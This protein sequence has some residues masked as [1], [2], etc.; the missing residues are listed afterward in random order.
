MSWTATSATRMLRHDVEM[1]GPYVL[2]ACRAPSQPTRQLFGSANSHLKTST[3]H[4]SDTTV[5]EACQ[6]CVLEQHTSLLH[7]SVCWA[8]EN[9][10]TAVCSHQVIAPVG[11]H[12]SRRV[13]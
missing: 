6:S 4:G 8:L 9:M 12:N 7:L 2:I 5:D 10:P 1:T 11:A 3:P 13:F